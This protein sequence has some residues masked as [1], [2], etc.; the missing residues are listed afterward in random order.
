M[1]MAEIKKN[2]KKTAVKAENND[3]K[4]KTT[5]RRNKTLKRYI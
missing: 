5:K 1:L 2:N 3:I 4:E